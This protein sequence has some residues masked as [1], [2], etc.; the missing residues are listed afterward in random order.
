MAKHEPPSPPTANLILGHLPNYQRDSMG[1]ETHV[2]RTYGDIVHMRWVSRHAYFIS[3]PDYVRQVLVD[4]ADKFYKAPIYRDL[5]SYFLGNGLLT[6][7]GDF[8]RR[9]RKLAQPAFHTK[10][11]QSYAGVMVDYTARL[12]SEWQPGQMRDLNRD[13][14][15]LTL[16]IVA[17]TLFNADIEKDANRIGNAL[18]DILEVTTKRIQSPI[19]VI[20]D[21]IPT[22][23]NKRRKAAVRELDA[24]VLGM[25]E[26]RRA[27]NE[28]QG[29][30][31][32]MLMLARDDAGQGM[33]DQQLR[34]EAV[35]IVLAGH[36]TTANALSW[37]WYLLAQHP[38]AEATLH[39]ELDRVLGGR[40]P[41]TDDLRQLPY[42]EMVIKESM[43]LYPPIPSFARLA[44]EDLVIG[45]YSVPKGMIVSM[46]PHVIHRDP[47]WYPEPDEFRPERFTREFEK[48]LPKGAYLPFSTGPRICIGNS[49]AMMEAVLILAT[50]AQRYRL[51]LVPGQT[52]TP[53]AALTLRPQPN[54]QV[55]LEERPAAIPAGAARVSELQTA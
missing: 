12:L 37:T 53:H 46:A 31:L 42:A 11:I 47:R 38:E 33:T 23:G 39:A 50:I 19:Q 16:S 40:L 7:D 26:Q 34:D 52:I 21:W 20:P 55:K 36:E 6:S 5:L 13:M 10:R 3:H 30:L 14:T 49:F 27:A 48:S 22:E 4:E 51:V 24:I 54:I 25:I 29:D 28:D 8:W 32:S 15:R 17:K 18:T 43:R 9:Q 2:A 45:G 1:Y 35:T 41:T 44:M